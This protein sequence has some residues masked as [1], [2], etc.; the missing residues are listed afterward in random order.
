MATISG[1]YRN[2]RGFGVATIR[3]FNGYKVATWLQ[4]MKNVAT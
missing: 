4:K 3:Y 2:N 1:K